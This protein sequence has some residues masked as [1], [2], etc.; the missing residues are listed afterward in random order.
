MADA[1]AGAGAG[2]GTDAGRRVGVVAAGYSSVDEEARGESGILLFK[3][4]AI[5]STPD[6]LLPGDR[7]ERGPG[8]I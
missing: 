7:G 6:T 5:T 2:A 3:C 4:P 8:L 1:G